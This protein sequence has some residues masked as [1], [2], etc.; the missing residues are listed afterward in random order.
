MCDIL[1][2]SCESFT[3]ISSN[4]SCSTSWLDHILSSNGN[5]IQNIDI[6]YGTTFYDH[7]PMMF[8]IVVP[9]NLIHEPSA[10]LGDVFDEEML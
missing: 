5:L 3:Y 2:L 8:E 4:I 1:E 10:C 9:D 7:V 6:L